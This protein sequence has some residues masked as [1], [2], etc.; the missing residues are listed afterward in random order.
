MQVGTPSEV[1]SQPASAYVATF[2]G[3]T[4]LFPA[5]VTEVGADG[6]VC[7]VGPHRPRR[8]DAPSTTPP[9]ATT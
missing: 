6:L 3:T 2:L 5:T 9:S 7:R 4:N 1:Y 8:R